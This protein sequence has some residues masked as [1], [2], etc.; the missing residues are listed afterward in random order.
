MYIFI[1]TLFIHIYY[2]VNKR[3]LCH[4]LLRTNF[5]DKND[6]RVTSQRQADTILRAPTCPSCPFCLGKHSQG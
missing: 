4:R 3:P 6:Y 1:L 2:I 5:G